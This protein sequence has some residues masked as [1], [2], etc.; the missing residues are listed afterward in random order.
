MGRRW[1]PP[2][3]VS[4]LKQKRHNAAST[5]KMTTAEL[6]RDLSVGPDKGPIANSHV[7]ESRQAPQVKHASS[8]ALLSTW[9]VLICV[10]PEKVTGKR[11]SARLE[12]CQNRAHNVQLSSAGKRNMSTCHVAGWVPRLPRHAVCVWPGW[13]R[14]GVAQV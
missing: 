13:I 10:Q 1:H 7:L 14:P 5:A 2:P 6:P 9:N 4:K 12:Q 11:D 8:A 3:H